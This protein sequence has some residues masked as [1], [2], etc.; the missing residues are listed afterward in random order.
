[1]LLKPMIEGIIRHV[2]T[3]AAG[4]MTTNGYI[5]G[6]ESQQAVGAIAFLVGLVWSGFQKYKDKKDAG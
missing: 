6:D 3:G 2:L 4:V 1:M 5:T